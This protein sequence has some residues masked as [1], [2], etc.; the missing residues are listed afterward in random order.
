M[1]EL[2]DKLAGDIQ[3][4]VD[5]LATLRDD[6]RVRIHLAGLEAK[7]RWDSIEKEL[8]D[9]PT[10]E[11]STVTD[12]ALATL[13]ATLAKVSEFRQSLTKDGESAPDKQQS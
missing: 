7:T 6:V 11:P 2:T 4:A 8:Q 1:S 9:V 10:G 3:K 12:S 5:D 13:R